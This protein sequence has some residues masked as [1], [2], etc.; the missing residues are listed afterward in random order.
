MSDKGPEKPSIPRP[1][2]PL[3]EDRDALK[4]SIPSVSNTVPPPKGPPE[5][6]RPPRKG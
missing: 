3:K 5:H 6:D 4:K 1:P 2:Q